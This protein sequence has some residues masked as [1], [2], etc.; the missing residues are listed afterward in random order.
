MSKFLSAVKKYSLI[1]FAVSAVLGILMIAFPDYM[2]TYAAFFVG[3]SFILCGLVGI[4][5]YLVKKDSLFAL[6]LGIISLISGAIICVAFRQ[7]MA[8]IVFLLGIL[9]LVGGVTDLVTSAYVAISKKRSWILTVL[10][11]VA[12]IVLGVMAISNP[13]DTQDKL[14]QVLGAGLV[15]FAIVDLVSYIQIKIIA[16]Q[17]Q[18]KLDEEQ[19][20][21]TATEVEFAELKSDG[22]EATEVD[23]VE[24]DEN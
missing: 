15:V 12:S 6:I 14:V 17:V 8:V 22:S 16:K 23:F 10:L 24:V 4:I 19:E 11:S 13:F 20:A 1:I 21:K 18:K 7:I 9:L 3:I 5:S 2:L